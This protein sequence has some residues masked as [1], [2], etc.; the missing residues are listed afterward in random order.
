MAPP[1]L[2]MAKSDA[3]ASTTQL[4]TSEKRMFGE[5]IFYLN[6]STTKYVI[7]GYE[8]LT[9]D[10]KAFGVIRQICMVNFR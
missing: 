8:A 2:K 10:R 9:L 6:K 3:S 7:V 5:K 1:P 4:W